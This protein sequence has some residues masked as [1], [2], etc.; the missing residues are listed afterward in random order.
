MVS[1]I[2]HGIVNRKEGFFNY[3]GW[4]SVCKDENG[5]LYAV[6][7]SFRAG[8]VCPFGKTVMYISRDDGKTWSIPM[9]I[10]DT[11]MDDRDAGILY[12]GNGK[13]LVSWFTNDQWGKD[14]NAYLRYA[15]NEN[16]T[17]GTIPE[18][19]AS[20]AFLTHPECIPEEFRHG[21]SYIRI[22]SDY[23]MTWGPTIAVPVS[24]P[25]GPNLC[26]DGTLIYLGKTHCAGSINTPLC[27]AAYASTDG[28]QTW[29]KRGDCSLPAGSDWMW[30]VEP[31]VIELDDGTLLGAAR[32]HTMD[33]MN[34][35]YGT[36]WTTFSHDGGYTWSAF[37]CLNVIGF[38]PH[39]YKHSSGA[40]ILSYS[41]REVDTLGIH[42]LISRDNGKTWE[43]KTCIDDRTQSVDI[44]YPATVELSDGSLLTVYYQRLEQDNHPSILYTKW[45]LE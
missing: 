22:S 6:S 23:G 20:K 7:S 42:V 12:L 8:H 25:H 15:L 4:P 13:L 28:G 9:I 29:H 35:G 24:A 41:C 31:H 45:T 3:Q 26:K 32:A 1:V 21:G 2:E 37:T 39:F 34:R 30:F 40:V 5:V 10:N 16:W 43:K 19:E 27:V 38:P 36:M 17:Q 11:Y 18:K 44:G 14:G 33:G